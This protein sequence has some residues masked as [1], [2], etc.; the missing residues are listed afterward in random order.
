MSLRKWLKRRGR[1]GFTLIELLVVI[2]IIAILI[3][4]LVP[5]VQKVREA[6]ARTQCENNLKQMG[7]G[8]QSYHDIRKSLP[9]NGSN[10]TNPSTWC[11]QFQILPYIE[12]APL[13]RLAGGGTT[14]CPLATN[15]PTAA[16]IAVPVYLCPSRGR[17][18]YVTATSGNNYPY[19]DGP[20]TDYAIN[21]V[22]F[23]ND[24]TQKR[25]LAVITNLNGSSNTILWGEVA[26]DTNSYQDN[27]S[28]N[29][30]ECIYSGG[31]GGTGRGDNWIVQD[32]PG[33]NYGNEWGS[34]HPGGAQFCYADG[35]VQMISYSFSRS[36]QMSAALNYRNQTPFSLD[37]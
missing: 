17:Q 33:D 2:A 7:L 1:F 13:Y 19:F 26:I 27:Y 28:A 12:Q 16:S 35:H 29:W 20:F 21:W 30:H 5:A 34:A 23:P 8:A 3:G 37:Q 31:Y 6:A 11:G 24:W 14:S 15:T 22:S 10:G 36:W 25:P 9:N 18:G 4:L 32:N